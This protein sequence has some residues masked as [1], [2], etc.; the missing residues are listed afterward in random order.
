MWKATRITADAAEKMQ[1][2][3]GLLLNKFDI[4]NPVEPEEADIVCDTSGDFSLTCVPETQDLFADVNNAPLNTMEGKQITG[5]NCGLTLTALSVTEET[6]KISLGACE[7]GEDGGI[8]PRSTYK[9]EDFKSLY[10]IGDMMEPE[11]LFCVVM[12]HTVSTGGLSF[13]ATNRGKGALSLTLTPHAT[14]KDQDK[15]PMA[16]YIL[17]KIPSAEQL[18]APEIEVTD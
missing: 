5:W 18:A 1:V 2:N 12:D 7:V 3:A 16:F 9:A 15:I 4:L 17:E 14:I 10:W 6:L 8:H 13:T 11:K